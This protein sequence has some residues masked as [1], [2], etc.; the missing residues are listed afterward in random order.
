LKSAERS[1]VLSFSLVFAL[2]RQ[3]HLSCY[4]SLQVSEHKQ[5]S[6]IIR[7][8]SSKGSGAVHP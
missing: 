8:I 4:T 1:M 3:L 6:A 5:S 2:T 7:Q